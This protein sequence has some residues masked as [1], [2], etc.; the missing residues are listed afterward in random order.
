MIVTLEIHIKDKNGIRAKA[1]DIISVKPSDFKGTLIELPYFYLKMD[2]GTRITTLGDAKKLEMPQLSDGSLTWPSSEIEP[3]PT[4]VAKRRYSIS[5]TRL[6]VVATATGFTLDWNNFPQYVVNYTNLRNYVL[7][8]GNNMIYDKYLGRTLTN[9]D[10]TK[11]A[12]AGK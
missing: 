6:Q 12:D 8:F 4:I 3:Q 11:I 7:G 2:F 9:T 10:L 5:L 1:G